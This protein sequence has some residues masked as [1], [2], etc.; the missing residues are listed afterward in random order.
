[1]EEIEAVE[2]LELEKGTLLWHVRN[3]FLF[4]FYAGGMRFS[5]V[6]TLRWES[7]RGDRLAYRMRKTDEVA[8]VALVP[9]ALELLAPYRPCDT[10]P[11]AYVFPVLDGYNTSTPALLLRAIGTRNTLVNKYLKKIQAQAGLE[12]KLSFHLRSAQPGRLPPAEGVGPLRHFEG[13]RSRQRPRHRAV[14]EGV[15]RRRPRQEDAGGVLSC[16]VRAAVSL[17]RARWPTGRLG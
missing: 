7:L 12:T 13:A 6:A 3:W 17:G 2:G 16:R 15:R 14:P 9:P 4:A 5:D 10:G 1:M 11:E 8:S